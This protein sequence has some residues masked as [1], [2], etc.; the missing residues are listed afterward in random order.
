MLGVSPEAAAATFEVDIFAGVQLA[1]TSF[2]PRSPGIHVA[3]LTF[4][5][6]EP[7]GKGVE[8]RVKVA[9]DTAAGSL[10]FGRVVLQ[11]FSGSGADASGPPDAFESVLQL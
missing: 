3:T 4:S 7:S 1:H 6:G 10:A 2:V 9:S 5:I 11:P 8:V